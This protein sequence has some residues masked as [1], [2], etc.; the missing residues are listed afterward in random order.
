MTTTRGFVL[1]KFYPPHAG[2]HHLIRYAASRVD[3]LVVLAMG[4]RI[5]SIPLADRVAWLRREHASDGNVTV[6]SA[7]CDIPVDL[8]DEGV[9]DAQVA[10]MEAALEG[11]GLA[12]VD[13]VFSSEQYGPELARRLHARHESVDP[14]RLTIPISA[15]RVRANLSENWHLLAAPTRE[16]L[17]T[18]IVVVGAE[19]TGTTTVSRALAEHYRTRG[20][21]WAQT[22]WVAEYGREYTVRKWNDAIAEARTSGHPEP[23]MDD[24]VWAHD[25]FAV[26]AAEQTRQENEAA[27]NGSPLVVCDTDA[28]ATALWERR[29]LG[30]TST[31]VA[32][33]AGQELPGRAIY[34]LTDHRG[35]PFE[36]DGFR[37][38][39]HIRADMHD[40]FVEEL[41]RAGHSWALLTGPLNSRMALAVRIT[42]QMLTQ[43]AQFADP[44]G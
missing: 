27:A 26:I 17:A 38:G 2:H 9:W 33:L 7:P 1:G 28:F 3:E 20:G 15:T 4:A 40:W 16:A 30:S 41:T 5:E 10:V 8:H 32:Q 36:Q 13:V 14:A 25:E 18:R 31:K 37:D 21:V 35:V 11:N 43:R 29:Y 22:G 19:S 44:L 24:L 6:I 34:L 12:P 23:T 39:E 42:D